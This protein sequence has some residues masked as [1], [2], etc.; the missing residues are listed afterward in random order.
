MLNHLEKFQ[1]AYETSK[2]IKTDTCTELLIPHLETSCEENK[3]IYLNLHQERKEGSF[4]NQV[5]SSL[6]YKGKKM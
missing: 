3:S 6:S 1:C 4:D 2:C 5:H